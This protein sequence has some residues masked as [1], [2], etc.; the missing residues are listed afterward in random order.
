M[1]TYEEWCSRDIRLGISYKIAAHQIT[2][3]RIMPIQTSELWNA[4]LHFNIS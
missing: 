1:I 3:E 2:A 4:Y